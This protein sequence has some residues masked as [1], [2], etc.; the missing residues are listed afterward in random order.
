MVHIADLATGPVRWQPAIYS[1][2][3][4]KSALICEADERGE[5]TLRLKLDDADGTTY[6]G[7]GFTGPFHVPRDAELVLDWKRHGVL[8][9]ARVPPGRCRGGAEG[10]VFSAQI[11]LIGEDWTISRIP[12]SAFTRN[13][14]QDASR[15]SDGTL[16]PDGIQAV[17]I[18]FPSG[19]ADGRRDPEHRLRLGR[20]ARRQ[21]LRVPAARRRRPAPD[22][23]QL[24]AG[25]AH[26]RRS[27]RHGPPHEPLRARLRDGGHAPGVPRAGPGGACPTP[28]LAVLAGFAA[29]VLLDEAWAHPLQGTPVWAWR[30]MALLGLAVWAGLS[31]TPM[32]YGLLCAVAIAPVF[33]RPSWRHLAAPRRPGRGPGRRHAPAGARHRPAA[34]AG[35]GE[36]RRAPALPAGA[37]PPRPRSRCRSPPGRCSSTTAS[38]TSPRSASTRSTRRARSP[39][40]TRA[41]SGCWVAPPASCSAAALDSYLVEEDRGQVSALLVPGRQPCQPRPAL[42]RRDRPRALHADAHPGRGRRRQRGRPPGHLHRHQRAA[43]AGRGAAARPTASCR[44][45]RSATT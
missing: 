36:R 10:E 25:D 42:R 7:V 5:R 15:P 1:Y 13:A 43:A 45:C 35:R 31:P 39:R 3:E 11:P 4:A 18:G 24:L 32:Q 29:L 16:N 20:H 22:P 17:E 14:F 9:G 33:E 27:D 37:L 12:L 6:L 8:S 34:P 40:S 30:F 19:D 2:N 41:S 21:R 44:P 28:E 26:G 23:A 38:S